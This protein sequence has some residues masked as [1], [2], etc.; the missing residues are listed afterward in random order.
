[1]TSKEIERAI[2]ED[3][4]PEPRE[5]ILTAGEKLFAQKGFAATGVRELAKEANVNIA[6]IN[7]Y[8]GS[9]PGVL[10][11]IIDRFFERYLDLGRESFAE[12]LPPIE[13]LQ[14][15]IAKVIQFFRENQEATRIFLMELP[16]DL[17][18]IAEFKAK[19]IGQLIKT[20]RPKLTESFPLDHIPAY[21]LPTLGPGLVSL[22]A[23]HFLLKPIIANLGIFEISEDYY[24]VYP[25]IVTDL[26]LGGIQVVMKNALEGKY[27][28]IV[29]G[30][31][32][33]E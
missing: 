9:K 26:F 13:G 30:E 31:N 18:E 5:R 25:M 22:M 12:E 19:R 8:F 4:V 27:N 28:P 23:S 20:I 7:Y 16:I 17:P 10:M 24:R 21:V 3:V 11:A 15:F 32:N 6:M 14:R 1:M 2:E 29:E 33:A